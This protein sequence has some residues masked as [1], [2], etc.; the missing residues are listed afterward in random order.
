MMKFT[1]FDIDP[2]RLAALKECTESYDVGSPEAEWPNNILSRRTIVFG[3]GVIARK[4]D[5][6]IHNVDSDELEC[7][8]KLATEA[9][10]TIGDIDVGMGSES[11]DQ[12]FPFFVCNNVNADIP[13]DIDEH[14]I[15]KRFG[16]TIFPPATITVE[17]L[18]EAGIWW[19]EVTEEWVADS[20]DDNKSEFLGAWR[21]L[22]NWFNE[23][24]ELSNPTFVRIGDGKAPWATEF[25]DRPEGTEITGC[26]LP[27]MA[28]ALTKAGSLV[29][30]FGYT[31]QT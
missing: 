5:T 9:R 2:E 19:S 16:G 14:L 23:Q 8:R 26:V 22:I 31:V 20:D 25:G 13:N 11:S 29:G 10:Q 4:G 18:V 15:R 12:F 17:P 27:R 7:C 30:I 24:P 3:S 21:R 1:N 6:I 28:V